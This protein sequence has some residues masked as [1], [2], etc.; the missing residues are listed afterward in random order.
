MS[1]DE[2]LPDDD[3]DNGRLLA[4][5][6]AG[7]LFDLA[8]DVFKLTGDVF[9]LTGDV[10]KLNNDDEEEEEEEQEGFSVGTT[11][12]CRGNDCE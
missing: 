6:L 7:D 12:A 3:I 5:D 1:S 11:A 9:K 8:G 2:L 4:D 10:F